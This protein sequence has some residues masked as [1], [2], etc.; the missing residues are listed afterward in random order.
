MKV[1]NNYNECLTNLA[2]SIRKYFELPYHHQTLPYI[3]KILEEKKPE[4]VILILFDGMGSKI[5]ERSLSSNDLFI[6]NKYKEITTVFPAT[7]TAAT[8]SIRTGLNPIEHG[9]LG[10]NTYINEIDKT[11][12]LFLNEEKNTNKVSKEF[13]DY[14]SKLSYKSIAV[15][16]TETTDYI[17]KEFFPFKAKNTIK[18]DN[19]KH[20]LNLLSEEIS[21]KGKK[22]LYLY[23]DEPDHSM[24]NY[25]PNSNIVKKIIKEKN[26]CIKEFSKKIKN[27]IVFIVAD[28]GHI[29]VDNIF[30]KDYKKI[31]NMLERTTS[32]EPRAVSFK[33]KKEFLNT[34]ET[35][36]KK[37]FGKHF[38]LYSNQEIIDANLFG[39]GQPHNIFKDAIGDFIAIAEDSNKALLNI[40]DKILVS[41]HAG[42][43]DDE[44]LVPLIIIDKA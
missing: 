36:F 9:Y 8:T 31:L 30:L 18:Y 34:F 38:K 2:C 19:L 28:H 7:T 23:D 24:H 3:D 32:I 25:G 44:I 5:L 40:D 33:V 6:K 12:T 17:G 4:N 41:Q 20:G 1:R 39:Y 11:I 22:F 21:K 16:I 29:K 13:L 43:T 10:W 14:K 27:T 42:Y 35:E 37:N 26:D 15:E